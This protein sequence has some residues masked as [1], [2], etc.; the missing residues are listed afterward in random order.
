LIWTD[1]VTTLTKKLIDAAASPPK[2]YVF[3]WDDSVKGFGL[4]ITSQGVK[5]FVYQTRINGRNKRITIGRY[6]AI[7]I[8][9]GRREARR[10]AGEIAAG[11]DPVT[12][13]R[14]KRVQGVTLSE[15]LTAYL[16]T[17]KLKPITIADMTKAMDGFKDWLDRPIKSITRDMV[18][19]RH[20]RLGKASEARANLA[21]RYLRALLNFAAEEYADDAG[22]PLISENP[23]KKLS[24]TRSWFR[25]DRR[26]TVIKATEL[27][28]W[29][30]AVLA[31]DEVPGREAG[32]GKE[33][34]KLKQGAVARDFFMLVLLTGLRRSEALGLQ[35]SDVDFKAKTLV[36][37]DT[38][39]RSD[40]ELPLS[41]Y[42]VELL[43]RR[44]DVSGSDFVFSD[45]DG[46]RLSNLRFAQARV[47]KQ[48]GVGFCLHDLRRTFVSVAESLDI[49]AYSL[50]RL[51][52]HS[53][54]GD[55]TAGY[56]VITTERLREPM[57]KITK[58]ILQQ[59]GPTP[60]GEV[61]CFPQ[62]KTHG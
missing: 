32:T 39:N 14:K 47:E 49:P 55:V 35:W 34:P 59:A 40:H 7:T 50:K 15:V 51:L 42:L 10:L 5:S 29:V 58:F 25:I 46:R 17:R 6:D 19:D 54:A 43:T 20:R 8:D 28:A 26:R 36:V 62:V 11:K 24:S 2:D 23:V 44:Q 4:R 48:C 22:H 12:E 56:L 30:K 45:K 53:I 3:L 21:M 31:L 27:G 60:L 1:A 9:Q 61:I 57:E 13:K 33:N 52:N 16:S 38:K 37:R 18:S 41:N